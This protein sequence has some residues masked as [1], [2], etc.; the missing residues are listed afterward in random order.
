MRAEPVL[1][2]EL[3]LV[4]APGHVLTGGTSR[5]PLAELAGQ[6][7]ISMAPDHPA[8]QG[9]ETALA[10]AGAAP[11]VVVA[12]PGYALVCALVSAGLGVGV[13]PEMVAR[14][15]ATPVGTRPL[16]P[17]ELRRTIAVVHRAEEAAPAADAF[18]ALLRGAFG[19]ARQTHP[20]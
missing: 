10:R 20:A 15:A 3:V 13:V 5:L 8:R 2:E 17:G 9:V 18:R 12:T 14:T 1:V 6:P 19:R 16:D 7:L 4:T 11:S